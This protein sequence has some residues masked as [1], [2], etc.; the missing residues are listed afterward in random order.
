MPRGKYNRTG[1]KRGSYK[2]SQKRVDKA[3]EKY[4]KFEE[5]HGKDLLEE[6]T[7]EG[8]MSKGMFNYLYNKGNNLT[9]IKDITTHRTRYKT[10]QAMDESLLQNKNLSRESRINRV[11]ESTHD[12]LDRL[13]V[14][15]KATYEK[16]RDEIKWVYNQA[17][18]EGYDSKDASRLVAEW[19]FGS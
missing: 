9:D 5:A 11:N 10:V 8:G 4:Q 14:E 13:Q 6:Y 12:W 18:A 3:Y 2:V 19:F 16:I 7:F 15:D 1:I 17:K